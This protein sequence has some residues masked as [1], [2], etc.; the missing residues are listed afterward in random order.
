MILLTD[1]IYGLS[2]Y[3]FAILAAAE[4]SRS[5]LSCD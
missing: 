5:H 1:A 3:G 2:K 4:L